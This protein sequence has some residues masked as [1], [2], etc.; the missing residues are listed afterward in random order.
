VLAIV[1]ACNV[2]VFIS[3]FIQCI[4]LSS[5]WDPAVPGK[6]IGLAVPLGN[7]ILHIVTDFIIIALPLPALIK[8]KMNARRKIGLVMVFSLGFL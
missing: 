8:L 2:W 3:Q 5:I 1:I 4:P 6:C 7:S